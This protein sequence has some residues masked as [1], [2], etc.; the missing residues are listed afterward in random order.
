[1]KPGLE[2]K[3]Q[4]VRERTEP[5]DA[6]TYELRHALVL[7]AW[8]AINTERELDRV[9]AAVAEVLVPVVPF[10]GVAIIVP[11]A[12]HSAPWAMHIVGTPKHEGVIVDE[13]E[14]RPRTQTSPH[15]PTLEKRLIPYEE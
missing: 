4:K 9:L 6:V 12:R 8:E 1:M 15:R 10:F 11:E 3:E 13:L 14:G 2:K 7:H 5:R